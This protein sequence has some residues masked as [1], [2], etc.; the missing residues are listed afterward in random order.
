MLVN[1]LTNAANALKRIPSPKNPAAIQIRATIVNDRVRVSVFDNGP[2]MS[3]QVLARVREPFFTTAE[4]GQGMGLGLSIC[5]TIVKSHGGE[6]EI[7]S[8]A[9]QGTTVAFDLPLAST[10]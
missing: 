10:T 2:G 5:D 1:L 9:G 7:E 4:P 3:P 6:L 8:I